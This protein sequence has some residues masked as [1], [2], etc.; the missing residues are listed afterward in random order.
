VAIA[1]GEYFDCAVV[2]ADDLT[3][4]GTGPGAILT[5]KTCQGK[6]I[7]VTVGKNITIRDLTLTRA[8]V[9]DR[10]GAGIR[11][12]GANLTVE[13][14]RFI[15]NEEGI[16]SSDSPTST[17]RVLNSVFERNGICA[18]YCAHGIYV[19]RIALLD[20]QNT[21]F[22]MTKLGHSVKSRASRTVLIGNDIEDGPEGT[23]SYLVE[24]PDGGSL[25]MDRNTLEK[26]PKADNP[27]YA[28][29]IASEGDA[30]PTLEL[31]VRNNTYTSDQP[32]ETN[33][34]RNLTKTDAL[35]T[36]NIFK[37]MVK[38]LEGPGRVQ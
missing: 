18:D 17:I 29:S 32:H 13:N 15:D 19:G 24:L 4:E 16:L 10:N 26:G 6:A 1:P 30:V 21:R 28:I 8:R 37:G 25:L 34:V 11:A 38:P 35:L 3:I 27:D 31:I 7:L 23:S 12:E 2:T 5:D 22:F 20:I 33:F 14:T 9:A 36:G